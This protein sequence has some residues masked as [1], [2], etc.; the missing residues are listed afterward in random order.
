M[1]AHQLST[2]LNPNSRN[3]QQYNKIGPRSTITHHIQRQTER[4]KSR[5]LQQGFEVNYTCTY[6]IQFMTRLSKS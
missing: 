3:R 2:N 4:Y 1:E 5:R 6:I